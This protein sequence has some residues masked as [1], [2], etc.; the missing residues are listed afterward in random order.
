MH[1]ILLLVLVFF[2]A[3]SSAQDKGDRV[4]PSTASLLRSLDSEL[5]RLGTRTALIV[6]SQAVDEFPVWSPDA[7]RLAANVAG[8][9]Y[10]VRLDSIALGE[11][12]WRD[13]LRLGVLQSEESVAEAPEA[14][15]W[16]ETA[17]FAPSSI[18]TEGGT[19]VELL[20]ARMSTAFVITSAGGN[21]ETLWTSGFETCHS[22]SLAPDGRYVAFICEMNGVF[23]YRLDPEGE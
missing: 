23:L 13:G 5:D 14:A 19:T 17:N 20:Q 8:T 4:P 10:T 22:L 16:Q 3:T 6:P 11:A 1:R 18:R 21:A 9:W 2:A 7:S 15:A 12:T